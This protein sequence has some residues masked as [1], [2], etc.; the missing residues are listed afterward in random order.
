[1][2]C[3]GIV[4]ARLCHTQGRVIA[5]SCRLSAS[6][7]ALSLLRYFIASAKFRLIF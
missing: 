5:I 2:Q 4:F 1:M 6:N 3:F 7:S